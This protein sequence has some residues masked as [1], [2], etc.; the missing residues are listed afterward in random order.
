MYRKERYIIQPNRSFSLKIQFQYSFRICSESFQ[1]IPVFRPVP[2]RLQ[3][4]LPFRQHFTFFPHQMYLH[5]SFVF[6]LFTHIKAQ[7]I[8]FPLHD[9]HPPK[10]RVGQGYPTSCLRQS[11]RQRSRRSR[12]QR[13]FLTQAHSRPRTDCLFQAPGRDLR[14]RP[15]VSGS[16]G[17]RPGEVIIQLGTEKLSVPDRISFRHRGILESTV[18]NQFGI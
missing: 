13:I 8:L 7:T 15:T 17:K 11:N 12:M 9:I 10:S 4:Y 2:G 6:S 18:L 14:R 16:S 1:C 3:V 5:I